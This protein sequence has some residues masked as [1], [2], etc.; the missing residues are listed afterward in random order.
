MENPLNKLKEKLPD[1]AVKPHPTKNNMSVIHPMAVVDRLNEV[2]GVGKWQTEVE[3]LSS[4]KWSQKTTKGERDVY[5]STSIVVFKVPEFGIHLEQFGGSTN[6]DEGDALKGSATD[7][8]TKIASYLGVGAEIYKGHGNVS[9]GEAPLESPQKPPERPHNAP[10]RTQ[11][12][13]IDPR[14]PI[15][16]EDDPFTNLGVMC[17]CGIPAKLLSVKKDGPNKGRE[18][19]ACSKPRTEQCDFFEWSKDIDEPLNIEG[20]KQ[21]DFDKNTGAY[22]GGYDANEDPRQ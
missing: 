16:S 20:T 10:Q 12:Q 14:V 9:A 5:T 6:D 19:Y 13:N 7:G 8:L 4:L 1:W 17:K 15:V 2:F 11:T 3:K 21:D 18:F 22:V